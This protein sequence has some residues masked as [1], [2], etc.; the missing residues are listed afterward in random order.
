MALRAA[1]RL[2]A[3]TLLMAALSQAASL[4]RYPYLQNVRSDRAT[5]SWTSFNDGP[6]IVEYSTDSSF[7]NRVRA[8]VMERTPEE[9]GLDYTYYRYRA[10]LTG[11]A[12]STEYFYRV[13]IDG[14]D[15]TPDDELHF[16]TRAFSPFHF[17]AFGDSGTGS[18]EQAR[19]AQLMVEERPALVLHT[20]DIV[21]PSGSFAGYQSRYFNVYQNLMKRAAFFPIPGNHDYQTD[22]AWS[23]LSVHDLPVEDVPAADHERYYSYDWGNVHFIA[24]DSNA[25]LTRAAN[26]NGPM[27]AWLENDLRNARQFWRVAYFHH[28]PYAGGPNERDPLSA[29]ARSRIVPILEKHNVALVLNGHEH[30][31]QRSWPLRGGQPVQDGDGVVYLTTGGGGVRLYP[32]FPRPFLA[33]AESVHHFVRAEVNGF[34]MT[35]RAIGM[36][37]QEIDHVTLAPPP[38]ISADG[39]VNTASFTPELA[40]GGLVSVFG[41]QLAAGEMAAARV[42]L[43]TSLSSVSAT[44]DGQRLPLFYVSPSQINAQLPFDMQGP[45]TLRVTT[46]NGTSEISVILSETAPALFGA[47]G[48]VAHVDGSPVTAEL[49]A[50]PGEFISVFLIGLGRVNGAIAPGQAAPSS[51][52]LA[53]RAPVEAQLGDLSIRPVFAGLAPGFAGLYQVNFQIPLALTPGIHPLRIVAGGS[54]S[55]A[56]NVPVGAA[57]P[58]SQQ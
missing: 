46:P 3:A 7:S 38:F 36:D 9:T 19:L 41:R 20:G 34:Q 22:N 23:Y 11:L 18:A 5:I 42:P 51:P 2:A 26:G 4:L 33:Y 35:L 10:V 54:P 56:V 12:G 52:P 47:A 30:S 48:G 13:L 39:A 24:L 57:E 1:C 28:P 27:L 37:R 53:V 16:R 55:N 50:R 29:L 21:Y 58:D 43:P 14:E 25:P 45:A 6:G 32:V 49:P 17:L 44:L 8:H 15:L 31:Y 40:P